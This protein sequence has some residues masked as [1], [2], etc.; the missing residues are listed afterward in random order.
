MN[1]EDVYYIAKK[2]AKE[3][4]KQAKKEL[5]STNPLGFRGRI[6]YTNKLT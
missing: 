5:K 6:I 3:Q 4:V 1:T 2:L